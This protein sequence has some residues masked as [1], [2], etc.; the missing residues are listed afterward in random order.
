MTAV[1]NVLITTSILLALYVIVCI[2][3]LSL[4]RIPVCACSSFP[5]INDTY[6]HY[7][8]ARGTESGGFFQRQDRIFVQ[9]LV[10]HPLRRKTDLTSVCRHILPHYEHEIVGTG[11]GRQLTLRS[12]LNIYGSG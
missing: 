1:L 5:R 8:V 7:K 10:N 12:P 4:R 6:V 2:A 11:I 3:T 9:Y